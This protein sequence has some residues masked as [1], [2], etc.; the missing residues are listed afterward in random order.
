MPILYIACFFCS[1]AYAEYVFNVIDYGFELFFENS[2]GIFRE[3]YTSLMPIAYDQITDDGSVFTASASYTKVLC[4]RSW[5]GEDFNEDMA[6]QVTVARTRIVFQPTFSGSGP[7]INF[8]HGGSTYDESVVYI[9]D[10]TSGDLLLNND[11]QGTGYFEDNAES[12]IYTCWNPAHE[13]GLFMELNI[14]A[15]AYPGYREIVTDMNFTNVPVPEP[16]SV[17]LL[18]ISLIGL[19]VARKKIIDN[20]S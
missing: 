1:N 7:T 3:S 13:Y 18:G 9:S 14:Q 2:P 10:F 15:N 20:I 8:T 11:G 4:N 6:G 16:T 19:T 17:A 12:F 5:N